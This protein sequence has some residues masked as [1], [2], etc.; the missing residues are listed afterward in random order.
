[1]LFNVWGFL[2]IDRCHFASA[3]IYSIFAA[4][5]GTALLYVL[6]MNQRLKPLWCGSVGRMAWENQVYSYTH[7]PLALWL[8]CGSTTTYT[9]MLLFLFLPPTAHT[10]NWKTHTLTLR[11]CGFPPFYS[12]GG[13]P[14]SPGMKKRIR[15][16]QY[17]FPDPE[18]TNV[19]SE[20]VSLIGIQEF[21]LPI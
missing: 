16:G 17:T 1:M 9:M 4:C 8:S 5:Y 15:Q 6:C 2:V 20:G 21:S 19:S 18:W 7:L 14:I 11:L 12:T 13:A 3:I 10:A